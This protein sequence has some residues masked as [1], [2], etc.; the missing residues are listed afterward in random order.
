MLHFR[1]INFDV[2]PKNLLFGL[3][4]AGFLL[5][6][7]GNGFASELGHEHE[8]ESETLCSCLAGRLERMHQREAFAESA[9]APFDEATG[10]DLRKFPPD[11]LVDYKHMK[12]EL[13]FEDLNDRSFIGRESLT[14]APIGRALSTL[15]LNAE[16]L[17]IEGVAI[18]SS[19]NKVEHYH[20]GKMLSLRFE[21]PIHPDTETTIVIDYRCVEPY[22]GLFFTPSRPEAPNYTAEVHTQGQQESNRFWFPCHDYPNEMLTTE[23]IVTVPSGLQVSSNGKLVSHVRTGDREV[24]HYL[25]DKPHV[26]YLVSLIIGSFDIVELPHERVPMRVWVP[27]GKGDLVMQ[28]YGNTAKMIDVFEERF[29]LP[30]PWARYDQLVVKNFG[31]GGMEN[32]SVTTMYPTAIFDERALLDSD[33]DGLIAH[34]LAHQW[35][36]DLIT[37][38]SWAHIWLNEGW[39]TYGESL[40]FEARDGVTGYLD[41]MMGNFRVARRDQTT[42][43]VPM[44]SI[45]DDDP[46][47]YFGRAANPY[48]KGAS[49]LHM[50]RMML[51]DDVFFRGVRLYMHRHQGTTVETND[52]RYALEEVSGLSLEWFFEQWCY[53]PGCPDL[54]V[55]SIYEPE[56]REL[57]VTV[58]QQQQIDVRTPAF[59][60]T[61]PIHVAT[62]QGTETINIEVSAKETVFRR[63]LSGPPSIVA[64][65]PYLHVLKQMKEEKSLPLWMA[66]AKEGPLHAARNMAIAALGEHDTREVV[67]LLHEIA[68]DESEHH[69]LRNTAVSSLGNLASDRA[70]AVLLAIMEN[71]VESARVRARLI[72]E[73]A[74]IETPEITEMLVKAASTDESYGVRNAA[75]GALAERKATE[76]VDLLCELVHYDS[77]HQ[78]VR[79]TALQALADLDEP[80]GLELAMQ[81]SAYGN[82]DRARSTA[83]RLVGQLAKHDMEKAVPFLLSLLNDPEQGPRGAA[84]S[85]LANTR[86][87]RAEEPLTAIANTDPD[88]SM[89]RRATSALERMQEGQEESGRP[90]RR[91]G[92]PGA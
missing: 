43:E 35:T 83:I 56:T 87:Q 71:G 90:S 92:P 25:Q 57:V 65:D 14:I 32:T 82:T 15:Q 67:E 38:K 2:R 47:S 86:D 79:T 3:A 66:Q 21:P 13:Q 50:L 41:D 59:R 64:V 80:R 33:L 78:R 23:L 72:S 55:K 89:R 63:A 24:W 31:A 88:P 28:T 6:A 16:N 34:E 91:G 11:R 22:D 74:E 54:L 29:G 18:G 75:I 7:P 10:A 12:L 76:H 26:N 20:D 9:H 36:G 42:N 8:H 69:T 39:A 85:A 62:E 49:I 46:G 27:Q 53:R 17:T 1:A 81:Y 70:R 61:L 4:L 68:A 58:S 19:A 5:V 77:Q 52:F 30:Y 37:C 73:I 45:I 44:V 60:F 48:S 51:G 84:I 40:W